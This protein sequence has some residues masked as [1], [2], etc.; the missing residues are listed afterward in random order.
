MTTQSITNPDRLITEKSMTPY[1][2]EQRR[3]DSLLSAYVQMRIQIESILRDFNN[4]VW[5]MPRGINKC[6]YR[7]EHVAHDNIAEAFT[8]FEDSVYDALEKLD[9]FALECIV[10]LHRYFGFDDAEVKQI[11]KDNAE[12]THLSKIRDAFNADLNHLIFPA[13]S[14]D[15]DLPF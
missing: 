12:L 11:L 7:W 14:H 15:N 3:R 13:F 10:N 8:D 5:V 6:P 2:V 9:D 4:M 1:S